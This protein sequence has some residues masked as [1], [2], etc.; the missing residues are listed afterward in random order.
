MGLGAG[1]GGGSSPRLTIGTLLF[2]V[3]A[4]VLASTEPPDVNRA[5]EVLAAG[6][7]AAVGELFL[8]ESGLLALGFLTG[9]SG[10]L[11]TG[12]VTGAEGLVFAGV[13]DG[14]GF[15]GAVEVAPGETIFT[16]FSSR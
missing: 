12:F 6:G 10:T 11:A 2:G 8:R 16:M 5:E 4:T 7:T 14:F 13:D 15:V 3:T 9:C 1:V